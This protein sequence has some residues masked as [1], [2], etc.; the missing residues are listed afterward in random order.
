MDIGEVVK[1]TRIPASTLRF[2]EEKG[3]IHAIGRQGLRRVF[4]DGVIQRLALITLGKKAGLT[5]AEISQMLLPEGVTINREILL[6]KANELDKQINEMA[7]MR[8]GLRHA[9]MCP[10]AEHLSCETFQRLL[11][12][13]HRR[14][15]NVKA[16]GKTSKQVDH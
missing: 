10:A 1:R 15:R 5:L 13:A 7:A 2:Y 14:W 4:D 8:D 12:I 3:L 16:V 6:N 11:H 9:A